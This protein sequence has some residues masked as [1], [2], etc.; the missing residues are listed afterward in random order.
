M[1]VE[2][3]DIFTQAFNLL[4]S[5]KCPTDAPLPA[6]DSHLDL[7]EFASIGDTVISTFLVNLKRYNHGCFLEYKM[8]SV[9]VKLYSILR[10]MKITRSHAS[11]DSAL[12][13]TMI[14]KQ[15]VYL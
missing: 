15:L 4:K 11:V 1:H 2:W 12:I 3:S 6:I 9:V 14:F 13:G 5:N 7:K 10:Q 8:L